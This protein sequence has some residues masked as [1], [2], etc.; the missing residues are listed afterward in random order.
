MNTPKTTEPV[1][2]YATSW[3]PFCQRLIADLHERNV[4]FEAWDVEKHKDLAKWVESVNGGNRVVP[5]VLYGDGTYSTNPP[6]SEV[7]GKYKQLA[8]V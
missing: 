8:R 5:T 7:E 6:A 2:I 1:T 3:C 4:P